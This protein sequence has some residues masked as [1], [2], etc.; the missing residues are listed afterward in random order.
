MRAHD[1]CI[2]KEVARQGTALR[3]EAFPELAPDP[4]PFPAA[5]AVIDR[6]PVPKVRRQVAPRGPRAGKIEDGFNE[7]PIAECRGAASAGFDGGKEGGNL[8]PCRVSQQQTYSHEVSSHM[9]G[10]EKTYP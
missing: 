7:H 3:L 9:N 2:D 6:V 4:A 5:K 8:R 1:R 10:R